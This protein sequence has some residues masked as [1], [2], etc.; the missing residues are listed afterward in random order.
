MNL[1][2]PE[3]AQ[4]LLYA[5]HSRSPAFG[6]SAYRGRRRHPRSSKDCRRSD[7]PGHARDNVPW[8]R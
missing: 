7:L 3:P 1:N 8:I 4:G 2:R 5:S 6:G